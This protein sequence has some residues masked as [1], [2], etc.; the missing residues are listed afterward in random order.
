M[1]IYTS[2]VD[3]VATETGKLLSGLAENGSKKRKG[4]EEGDMEGGEE[5]EEEGEE[6]EGEDGVRKR[7]KKRVRKQTRSHIGHHEANFIVGA[8]VIRGNPCV[9]FRTVTA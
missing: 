8:E 1:K 5:G 6:E 9:F 2:R 3:S 4:G 7:V